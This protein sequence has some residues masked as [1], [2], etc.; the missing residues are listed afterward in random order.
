MK[1]ELIHW[2]VL[3][4][5]WGIRRYQ[6][7]DGSLTA[8]GRRRYSNS[9]GSINNAL[10]KYD[11]DRADLADIRINNAYK[12]GKDGKPSLA[13]KGGKEVQGIAN[14]FTDL[15]SGKGSKKDAIRMKSKLNN[16]S[17][18]DL[19]KEIDRL[20]M[21]QRYASLNGVDINRGK[22]SLGETLDTVGKVVGI[23][24]SAVTLAGIIYNI[25]TGNGAG[26]LT[27]Q[28]ERDAMNAAR[29]SAIKNVASPTNWYDKLETVK[30][31]AGD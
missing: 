8:E 2:G 24:V 28:I 22:K 21:E 26:E 16:M 13:E 7:A 17:D 15:G 3:G 25:K 11:K 14:T 10:V 30:D 12:P 23:G 20:N 4:M 19:R 18:E 27:N 31:F 29:K 1:D 5:K 9:D 6:N